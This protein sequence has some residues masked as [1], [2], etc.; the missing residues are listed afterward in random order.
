MLDAPAANHGWVLV[1]QNEGTL[2]SARRWG[3]RE[4]ATH[5][6]EL[7]ITFTPPPPLAPLVILNTTLDLDTGELSVEFQSEAGKLYKLE[8][9]A[10]LVTGGWTTVVPDIAG[11]GGS[12]TVST[13]PAAGIKRLFFRISEQ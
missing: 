13:T 10:D 11:T 9:H 6:P 12:V 5:P 8:T 4:H 2:K 3:A 1:S 7:E